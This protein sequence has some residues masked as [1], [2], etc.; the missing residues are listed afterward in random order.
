M[1]KKTT[2]TYDIEEYEDN[3]VSKVVEYK[4]YNKVTDNEENI[5]TYKNIMKCNELGDQYINNETFNK[6][7]KV[8]NTC[9]EIVGYSCNNKGWK[10]LELKNHTLNKEY[11]K[12]YDNIKL[13]IACDMI[14]KREDIKCINNK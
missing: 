6:L 4:K 9:D 7:N 14:Q 5:F 2:I 8:G 12:T 13:D 1:I 10:I 11:E 3:S